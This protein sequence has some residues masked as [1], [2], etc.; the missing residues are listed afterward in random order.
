MQ[1]AG[2]PDYS[3][4]QIVVAVKKMA[5]LLCDVISTSTPPASHLDFEV[6]EVSTR[7]YHDC[8]QHHSSIGT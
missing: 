1:C 3:C 7:C 2:T 5:E 8:Q 6:E 4:T